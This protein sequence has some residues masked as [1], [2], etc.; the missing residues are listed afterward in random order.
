MSRFTV[1]DEAQQFIPGEDN[2]YLTMN[3]V[4][5]PFLKVVG[6]DTTTV[7]VLDR[8]GT[9]V[10]TSYI[11]PTTGE[12]FDSPYVSWE[13]LNCVNGWSYDESYLLDAVQKGRKLC[14]TLTFDSEEKLQ[15][16]LATL[17]GSLRYTTSKPRTY[18]DSP[19]FYVKVM[20]SGSI[21]DYI[22]LGDVD[23][24]YR[25]LA[26]DLDTE[27]WENIIYMCSLPMIE[28]VEA[29]YYDCFNPEGSEDL[30]VTGL[31]FGYPLESTADRLF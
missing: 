7:S 18:Q 13:N 9:E 11:F 5:I 2:L 25:K 1:L 30:V 17:D 14:A 8:M 15:A 19:L 26:I 24:H 23:E 29:S 10:I 27:E 12:Q 6:E 22:D 3:S 28:L 16:Y 20:R 31:L 21:A 4:G